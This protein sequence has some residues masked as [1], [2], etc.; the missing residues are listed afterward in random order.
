MTSFR[1]DEQPWIPVVRVDG[2]ATDVNLYE[3]FS[4]SEE[5][6]ALAGSP[7]EV[8]ALTRFLLAIAHLTET[9]TSLKRWNQLWETRT[10]FMKG[11]AQYVS[12]QAGAWDLFDTQYPF[13]QV[14]DLDKTRNPA[15]L[16]VYEAARKNNAVFADHSIE[17]DPVCRPLAVL[18]RGLITTNAYAGSSGGGY[19]SGPLAMRTVAT[20]CGR[21]LTETLL[22]NLLVQEEAPA[23][24]SWETYG[25]ST[26][27]TS[28]PAD[29]VQR[30][31]WTSRRAR[32]LWEPP[33][34][35]IRWAMLAPGADMSTTERSEDPMVVMCKDYSGKE[36]VP[37]KLESGRALWRSAH[38]LFSCQGNQRRL[39][40]VDQLRRLYHRG[41][42]PRDL[43]VSMRVCAVAGDAKGPTT[44]LWRDEM[45]PF[46][47]SVIADDDRYARLVRA[48]ESAEVTA[49]RTRSRIK[50]FAQRYLQDA[51]E[52]MGREKEKKKDVDRLLHELAPDLVEFWAALA[53]FGER[54]A[55]DDFDENA[56]AELLRSASENAYQRAIDRLPPT[57]RRF[58]AEF[59][60]SKA[61]HRG[62]T[63][64]RGVNP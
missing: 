18:A 2:T 8:A 29:L 58:R 3:V 39:A 19:R 47:V 41:L 20:L 27:D 13:G 23:K 55:C 14:P 59:A 32:L 21:N 34:A 4:R 25:H 10:E 62:E 1:L 33:D 38:V 40:A 64:A 5:F 12:S 45:L 63:K 22:L 17:T 36:Y 51:S 53:P 48:V 37:L 42:F 30:Y 7:P 24:Y 56:W 52:D 28:V 6:L 61:D 57:A 60:V 44:E 46:G 26:G 35:A 43:P 11:C 9:P 50:D 31:L 49:N 16:L 15:H 54:I